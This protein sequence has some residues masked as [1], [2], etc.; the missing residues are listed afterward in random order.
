MRNQVYI[1]GSAYVNLCYDLL[2]CIHPFAV[3]SSKR[4]LTFTVNILI[5]NNISLG[6]GLEYA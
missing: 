6:G 3:N 4:Y 2:S 1:R 5:Y